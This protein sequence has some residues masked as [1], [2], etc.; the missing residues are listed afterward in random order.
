MPHVNRCLYIFLSTA[1]TTS[2]Y[3]ATKTKHVDV[4][5]VAVV[6][7]VVFLVAPKRGLIAKWLLRWQ[8]KRR[9]LET[10]LTIHLLQHEGTPEEPDES[11]VTGLHRHK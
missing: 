9:F 4:V 6:L 7:G 11:D 3:Q 10:M 5:L 2:F 8:Q 1:K